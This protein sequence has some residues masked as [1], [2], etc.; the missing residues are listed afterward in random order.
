MIDLEQIIHKYL[1]YY[2]LMIARG[3]KLSCQLSNYYKSQ[4]ISNYELES[5]QLVKLK[6]LLKYAKEN[7]PYYSKVY[8]ELNERDISIIT[9]LDNLPFINK[10]IVKEH[11]NRLESQNYKGRRA[12][13][14]TGGSTGEPL[15]IWKSNESMTKELAATWRAYSWAG[16]RIGDRQARFWGVPYTPKDRIR[17]RLIDLASNRKRFPA[18]AFNEE[19]LATYH[20]Q[21]R[22]FKP[23]YF[24]GYVSM[25]NEFAYYVRDHSLSNH[26]DLKC[27]ISTSEVL[28][29]QHRELLETVFKTRVYNEYGCG[30]V[31]S[32][33]HEC[34][35]GSM[36]VMSENMI[37]EIYDGDRKCGSNETGEIVITELNN[38]AMPLIRYRIGDFAYISSERCS[39]GRTLPF[40]GNIYGRAYDTVRNRDGRLFHG[41]F[42]MYMFE[43]AQKKGYDIKKFQVIQKDLDN[44]LVKIVPGNGFC[45]DTKNMI[46][47]RIKNDFDPN[48]KVKFEIVDEIARETSGKMRLIVGMKDIR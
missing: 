19:N 33:A 27:I 38:Y 22:R 4:Y 24:Y 3:Q 23:A 32:I 45:E 8:A 13:K 29:Q 35:K 1:I 43:D 2:P 31:G 15:T 5:I 34:E 37:I 30:E 17:A 20:T 10:S 6:Q 36:H 21:L 7:V 41:E 16:V 12:K 39:C 25:L 42:F 18:F 14:T 47:T 48:V 44:L 9:D 11:H 28:T 40:I 26:Y 46:L